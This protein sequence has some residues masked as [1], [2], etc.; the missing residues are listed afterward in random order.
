MNDE[1]MRILNLLSEGKISA[2]EAEKLLDAMQKSVVAPNADSPKSKYFFV[3]VSPKEGKSSEKVMVKIPL[4]LLKTGLNIT[5]L[6]PLEAQST[7]QESMQSKGISFDFTSFDS[8]NIEEIIDAL[9]QMSIDVETD[10]STI[11][12]FCG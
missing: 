6:I 11:K 7:I 9:E 12:V 2:Q 5:K 10:E 1:R 8:Q 4:A 3:Q